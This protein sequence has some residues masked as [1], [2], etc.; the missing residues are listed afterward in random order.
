MFIVGGQGLNF[1]IKTHKM[2]HL[3]KIFFTAIALTLLFNQLGY[4][5]EQ[6]N[7]LKWYT[8]INEVCKLS[9]KTK[10]PV[11]AFFTGSDWCGWCHRMQDNVFAKPGFRAWAKKNVILM[12]LDF[13]RMKKLPD[14]LAN[15]N[16]SLQQFF[17]VQGFPTVWIF[18]I[19]KDKATNKFNITALGSLGYPQVEPGK[20][21]ATFLENVNKILKTKDKA[22]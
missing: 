18:N 20:E 12:E 6:K 8:D 14:T 1:L 7:G 15:Q 9:N 10:K 3:S 2:K 16:N 4:A 19:I 11:F 21:E 22:K 13:P 5:Q 17:K